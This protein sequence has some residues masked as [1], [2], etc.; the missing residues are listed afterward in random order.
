MG[1]LQLTVA[2]LL[3]ATAMLLGILLLWASDTPSVAA[4][5]PANAA[6]L[7][8]VD[9]NEDG[10]VDRLDLGIVVADFGPPPFKMVRANVNSDAVVD[11]L[12]LA[13]VARNLGRLAPRP[14]KAMR[15][16]AAFPKLSFV[17]LTSL[18]QPDDGFGRIFVTEQPGRIRVFPNDQ[19]AA[20]AGTF[21]DITD[22]VSE[23]SSEEGLLGLAFDPDF[24]NNGHFYAYYSAASPRCSTPRCTVV[25]R[26]SVS[27]D[28]PNVAA[29]S[30][31][32]IIMEIAQPFPNHK[33]GQ[34]AFGPDGYLYIGLGDGGSG[35]DPFGNGQSLG[36]FLGKVLRIDVR[37]VSADKNYRIPPDNPFIGVAG[38]REEIWAYGLRNPWRFSFD[39]RR[40]TLWLADVG[41]SRFDEVDVVKRGANYGWDIMEGSLCFSPPTGCGQ[42]SLELPLW[43]YSLS[44]ENCA[45]IGGY[46]FYGR[47]MPSLLEA[48]VHGDFCSGR[49]W[50]LRYDG[51]SVTEQ[52]LLVDS[53]LFISSFGQDLA[54]NLYILSYFE[55]T[56][57]RLIPA[58]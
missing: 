30:S 15:V 37:G 20:Q 31:D 38:A 56:I 43:E 33:G 45:I 47:G 25:S 5:T 8:V 12:D 42:T 14:M 58:E 51:Q 13:L 3:L 16:T 49:I 44:L 10:Y 36:T 28:D 46:V 7:T 17:R 23:A 57:Y 53:D 9:V 1:Q 35:G 50:G 55:G 27:G 4:R 11:V 40:G 52:L 24:R 6:N 34:L 54:R 21:L 41:Q 39:E 18:V 48:Y 32:L 22:R 2:L 26:F 29:P 19:R